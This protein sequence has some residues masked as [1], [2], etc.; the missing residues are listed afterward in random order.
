MDESLSFTLFAPQMKGFFKLFF[1]NASI[2]QLQ[3]AIDLI[4]K[5]SVLEE[6]LTPSFQEM[7]KLQSQAD[8]LARKAN[9]AVSDFKAH[10]DDQKAND[11]SAN[12]IES[13]NKL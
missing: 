5:H 6:K 12:L 1:K 3:H 4:H 2:S 10:E 13:L 7:Q 8:K 9:I 11:E